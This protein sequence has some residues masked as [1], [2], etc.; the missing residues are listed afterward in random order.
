MYGLMRRQAFIQGGSKCAHEDRPV[1]RQRSKSVILKSV[2]LPEYRGILKMLCECT[3]T[4]RKQTN[5]E[6]RR[7]STACLD[8]ARDASHMHPLPPILCAQTKPLLH[9]HSRICTTNPAHAQSASHSLLL[10][11][12]PEHSTAPNLEREHEE[13][14]HHQVDDCD[15]ERRQRPVPLHVKASGGA[16]VVSAVL[17]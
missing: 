16:L 10:S 14:H 13:G 9:G 12:I 1:V 3:E 8:D 11:K 2:A 4:S 6:Q 17:L 15:E 7:H 5:L